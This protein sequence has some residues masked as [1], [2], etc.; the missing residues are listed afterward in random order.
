[1]SVVSKLAV[2]TNTTHFSSTCFK[3]LQEIMYTEK[4]S[5]GSTIYWEGD[6]NENLY[7][8]IEGN[9]KLTKLSEDG[10]DLT[11]YYFFPGDIFGEF[12]PHQKQISVFTAEA[13][14]ACVI[15]V[16]QQKDLEVLLWQ[17]GDLAIE[18]TQWMSH[19]QHYTQLKVRDLLFHGKNGALASMLI[20][21][22]NTYGVKTGSS[23]RITKKFTNNELANLIGATRET[24][25]RMLSKF[26]RDQLIR[27][28]NGQI[29]ILNLAELKNLCRCEECPLGIC[30]L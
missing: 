23:I 6:P 19:M 27:Y 28:E 15:G 2:E 1:M 26:K 16:I 30:R 24:V 9:V 5:S 25:N 29:E 17:N 12:D 18:F 7:F 10:K 8:L 21:A 11:M 13:M 14:D 3:K 20:R 4:Y 22:S